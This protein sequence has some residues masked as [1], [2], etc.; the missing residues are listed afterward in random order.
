MANLDS[1]RSGQPLSDGQDLTQA[2]QKATYVRTN[3][4]HRRSAS[5]WYLAVL[6][7]LILSSFAGVGIAVLQT[8]GSSV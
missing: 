2:R 8:G 6:A 3:Q 4:Q 1:V 7:S 5:F